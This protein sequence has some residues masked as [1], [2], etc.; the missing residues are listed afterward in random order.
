MG[1]KI[2]VPRLPREREGDDDRQRHGANDQDAEPAESLDAIH[3]SI[4]P[5]SPVISLK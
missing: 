4:L 1:D 5:K 2:L 3:G